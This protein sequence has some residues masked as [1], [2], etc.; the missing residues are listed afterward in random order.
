MFNNWTVGRRLVAAFGLAA[1][2]LVVIALISYRNASRLIENDVWVA[3]THQVRAELADL[4]SEL[5]D[6]ETGQ[7]GYLI[8]GED[9]YLAPYQ[10]ALAAIKSTFEDVRKLTSDN[11]NQQRRFAT[12][13]PLID[14]KLAELKQTIDLRR[15]NGLDAAAKVVLSNAGK[16]YMD[17]TR[18]IVAD[19]D[20]EER[21]LLKQRSEEARASADMTMSIILWGGLLGTLAVG[22]IGW[23]ITNSLSAQIGTAVGQVRSSSTELQAAANQQANGA[24]EQSAAMTEIATTISELLQPR[25]KSP[26]APSVWPRTP[27]KRRA[28]RARA[29]APST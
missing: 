20:Q 16:G 10:S 9:S 14:A 19:A 27:N 25:G 23:F 12:I 4:L 5:K 15:T 21:A 29:T 8:T 3:H 2:T 28:R 18:A 1:L 6:A 11:P 13:A 26:K 24:K 17:Q 7:R 22:A